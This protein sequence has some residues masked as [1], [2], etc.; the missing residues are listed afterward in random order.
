[1]SEQLKALHDRM[2]AE[3]PE[4]V[5]HPADCPLCAM[6]EINHNEIPEGGSMSEFTKEQVDAAVAEAV[7]A[8]TASLKTKLAELESAAQETEV[9][10]A[11]AE[12]TGPLNDQIADLQAKLDAEVLARTTAEEA[13]TEVEEFWTKA[14]ADKEEADAV[15][16]RKDERL[17][18]L[19]EVAPEGAHAY[20]D[21]N[22]DRFA[23]MSDEDF[24]ARIEEYRTITAKADP[25][26][27]I[28]TTT[29]L[30]AA[31]EGASGAGTQPGSML[32]ELG[33][34]RSSLTDPRTL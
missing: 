32:S 30:T 4:G 17:T 26:S 14:I 2:M 15:A 16:A 19:K 33:S 24:D 22:A 13:K 25:G 28:P 23:A 8:A 21:E 31:R 18:K 34:L 20:L 12:A 7:E 10:K 5:P 3:K 29:A 9:G 27:E 6:G 1:M 11:V